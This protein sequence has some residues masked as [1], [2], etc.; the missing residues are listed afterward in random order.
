MQDTILKICTQVHELLPSKTI[1]VTRFMGKYEYG[2]VYVGE[3][4]RRIKREP[5]G[6]FMAE[7]D[8]CI[9]Y[10]QDPVKP[11]EAARQDFENVCRK[12]EDASAYLYNPRWY[13]VLFDVFETTLMVQF[14]VKERY[15]AED[16]SPVIGGVETEYPH[17]T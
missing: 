16:R 9:V 4:D 2:Q 13:S 8:F 3:L 5:C 17:V 14:T 7:R 6:Y 11:Q 1:A 10:S 15:C 12:L